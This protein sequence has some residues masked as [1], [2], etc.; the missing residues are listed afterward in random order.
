MI[1]G[2]T[3]LAPRSDLEQGRLKAVRTVLACTLLALLF[4]AGSKV[5]IAQDQPAPTAQIK[6]GVYVS[7]PFVMAREDGYEGMAVELWEDVAD[8]LGLDFSYEAYPTIRALVDATADR[9]IDVAVT[10]LT[11]TQNR[12]H[13]IDFTHPWFDAGLRILVADDR[14]A[15]FSEVIAGLRD[16][17]H[18]RAYA[19]LGL[20]VLAATGLLT[21]FD[22]RFDTN[23]PRRWREGLAESFHTVMSVAT[24]G[25]MPSRKNLFGWVGR[26]WQ[27]LW[28]VCGIAVLAYVTSSVTS[29]MTTLSL[30][31]QIN[32]LEDLPG[33]RVGVFTGSVAEEFARQAG[34]PARSFDDVGAAAAALGQERIA[35]IIGDAPVLE[36][37]AHTNPEAGLD[38]VGPIFEPDKY[39]FGLAHGSAL[40][41]PVTIEL[42]GMHE[43]GRIEALRERYFGEAQ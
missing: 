22:R 16:S 32:S 26:I 42:L 17:G 30:T 14:S 37:F 28:M 2:L 15:G 6:V 3:S 39:G 35:A 24:S 18:L 40:T 23:F 11:I 13:R 9:S 7:P 20:V 19:W 12:A 4:A 43:G 29:V 25:K 41:R 36:Y 33:K 10:N 1:S 34:M 38:V 21:V 27:A 8:R 5:A 31:N